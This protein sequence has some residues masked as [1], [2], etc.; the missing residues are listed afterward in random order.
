MI[1]PAGL[2]MAVLMTGVAA[3]TY[4]GLDHVPPGLMPEAMR[5]IE[6]AQVA[7]AGGPTQVADVGT[8]RAVTRVEQM[9][10][11]GVD[12]PMTEADLAEMPPETQTSAPTEMAQADAPAAQEPE[13]QPEPETAAE[14]PALSADEKPEPGWGAESSQPSAPKPSA[15]K[16]AAP[17]AA[18][19]APQARQA[20]SE[21]T[22]T[23]PSRPAADAIKPWWPDPAKM[24]ANQLKLQYAGQ[25]KGQPAVALLFSAPVNLDSLKLHAQIRTA[26]GDRATG[27]W[28]LGKNPR[29]AVFKGLK[30]GR[31]T[32][33]LA[34]QI[35][36][37][38]GFLLGTPLQGP[39]YIQGS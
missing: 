23:S 8:A 35:A 20:P 29:L 30:P 21:S 12:E 18:A 16:A 22:D 3:G 25:V 14:P 26:G 27:Q 11:T 5:R 38:Q 37:T 17:Q 15:P 34:P 7:P 19:S 6:T 4:Y 28:E 39:V 24:P 2:V 32:V 10:Q 1:K 13:S 9:E 31:Y 36:D 33:I